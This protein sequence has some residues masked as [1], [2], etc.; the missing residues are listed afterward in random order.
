MIFKPYF[1]IFGQFF[2]QKV[3]ISQLAGKHNFNTL[4]VCLCDCAGERSQWILRKNTKIGAMYVELVGQYRIY[5]ISV[6]LN[7]VNE[8]ECFHDEVARCNLIIKYT[9]TKPFKCLHIAVMV[10]VTVGN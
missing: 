2:V 1:F 8:R 10:V 6:T 7:V 3:A 4:A 5:H 9:H